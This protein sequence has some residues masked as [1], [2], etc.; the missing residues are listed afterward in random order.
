MLEN[1]KAELLT[2][3]MLAAAALPSCCMARH[4][5]VP[6]GLAMPGAEVTGSVVSTTVSMA[7][8]P[9]H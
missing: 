2:W 5:S 7:H 1:R 9:S 8:C 6:Q 4:W 3:A